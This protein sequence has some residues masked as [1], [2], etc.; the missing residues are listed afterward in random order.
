MAGCGSVTTVPL[1]VTT[2]FTADAIRVRSVARPTTPK[3]S[4]C[5]P[6]VAALATAVPVPPSQHAGALLGV[7]VGTPGPRPV[8]EAMAGVMID[9]AARVRDLQRRLFY[10][11]APLEKTIEEA[12]RAVIREALTVEDT[13]QALP[14]SWQDLYTAR[15]WFLSRA[16][17]EP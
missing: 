3:E 4:W 14:I 8:A 15:D 9:Y 6:L 10:E 7:A 12:L 11:D 2:R 1:I 16:G 13:D 17:V 5:D